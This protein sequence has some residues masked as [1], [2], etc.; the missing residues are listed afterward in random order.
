GNLLSYNR[1]FARSAI[2]AYFWRSGIKNLVFL[3]ETGVVLGLSRTHARSQ[4]GTR[5]SAVK[6]F[7]ARQ[8]SHS[9]WCN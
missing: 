9:N 3:D 4:L 8:K 2:V 7:Y 5:A 1:P 6:P